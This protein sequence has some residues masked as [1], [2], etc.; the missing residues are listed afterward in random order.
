MN[1]RAKS[2]DRQ[3]F[4]GG[5]DTRIIMG[6]DEAALVRLGNAARAP[7]DLSGNLVVQLGIVTEELNR[8]WYEANTGD[9]ITDVQRLVRH[10]TVRWM[11][12]TLDGRVEGSERNSC[13][14]GR[15]LRK[16]PPK[17]TCPSCSTTCGSSRPEARSSRSRG[18]RVDKIRFRNYFEAMLRPA[19]LA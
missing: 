19:P 17:N 11:G 5:S 9:V 4:I 10:P 16:R 12:A 3:Y 7:K 8:H 6:N 1:G 18:G 2:A 15:S 13:F 14:H